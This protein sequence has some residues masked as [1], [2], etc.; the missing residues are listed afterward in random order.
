[1]TFYSHARMR[2]IAGDRGL[3]EEYLREFDVVS[4]V[5]PFRVND[6]IVD[7]LIDWR[8]PRE[9]PILNL[10][11]PH[12]QMLDPEQFDLVASALGSDDRLALAQAV[13]KVREQLNP[14][15]AGQ[16]DANVPELDGIRL[17]GLQHK[18]RETL[19]VFPAQAQSCHAYCSYCFRWPQFTGEP[20][21]KIRTASPDLLTAYL[22]AHPEVTD[23]LLTGGDPLLMR[24]HVLL[25]WIRAVE[26]ADGPRPRTIR[27]GTKAPAYW[28]Q[29][30]LSDPDAGHL[31]DELRRLVEAGR[32]VAVMAHYSHPR[33]LETPA[34]QAAV[35][36]MLRAGLTVRSQAPVVAHVNDDAAV[37]AALWQRQA[38]LGISPYYMFVE[39]N[40]GAKNYFAIPLARA[41]D[42]Y[43]G[44]IKRVSGLGRTARGPVMSTYHGKILLNGVVRIGGD[45]AFVCSMMQSRDPE[46]VGSTFLAQYD[47]SATWIDDLR[48][49]PGTDWPWLGPDDRV[50]ALREPAS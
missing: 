9:D 3:G 43:V 42:I 39:R 27:I 12:R 1:M 15:P 45:P 34:A 2:S 36:A 37:W 28:P 4:A 6:Y 10:T 16:Q 46:L 11:F 14:H 35:R 41:L 29:R 8:R 19:L 47:E 23:V 7:H 31:L 48:P 24:T 32:P 17:D 26:A 13:A 25:P 50:P 20:Q 44:A 33:E 18:Y 22:R 5:L 38:D 21:R 49:L 30:F 40:T